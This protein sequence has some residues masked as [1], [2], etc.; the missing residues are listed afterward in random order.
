MIMDQTRVVNTRD[1]KKEFGKGI[2]LLTTF[3]ALHI[4]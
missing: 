2:L 3:L 1:Y 4:P